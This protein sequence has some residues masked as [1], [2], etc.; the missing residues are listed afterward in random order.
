MSDKCARILLPFSGSSS[1]SFLATWFL[2]G[3]D[4]KTA[5]DSVLRFLALASLHFGGGES[6]VISRAAANE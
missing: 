5:A 2:N 3:D 6:S 1:S 4:V